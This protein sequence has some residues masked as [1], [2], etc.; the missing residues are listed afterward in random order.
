MTIS[1]RSVHEPIPTLQHVCTTSVMRATFRTA[2]EMASCRGMH[3]RY[4]PTIIASRIKARR[5]ELARRG[6]GLTSLL[7]QREPCRDFYRDVRIFRV[8]PH[9][10]SHGS[11]ATYKCCCAQEY[12]KHRLPVMTLQGK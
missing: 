5:K 9:R 12:D 8:S 6:I 11:V 1:Y 4:Q 7:Y 10:R 3:F 2:K